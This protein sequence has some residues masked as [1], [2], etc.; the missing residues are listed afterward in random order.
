M[1]LAAKRR[2]PYRGVTCPC[3]E[4]ALGPSAPSAGETTCLRCGRGFEIL[5]FEPVE[6]R[7]V[8]AALAAAGPGG[9]TPCARHAG[10]QAEVAC[11]RCGQFICGLCRID[12]DGQSW[13]P[14]CFERLSSEGALAGTARRFRNYA[15]LAAACLLGSLLFMFLA[16]PLGALGLYW[17]IRGIREKRA[18]KEADG[19]VAL[20]ILSVLCALFSLLGVLLILLLFG[21][22]G[23]VFR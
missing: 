3:C 4:A 17:S 22:L 13:C 20:H 7:A 12:S 19:R 2:S 18:R 15:R 16:T 10:N 23:E 11:E 6:P 14:P 8:G 21:A 5:R 1:V 9:A